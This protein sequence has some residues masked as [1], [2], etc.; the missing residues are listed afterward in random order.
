MELDRLEPRYTVLREIGSGGMGKVFL[1]RDQLLGKELALKVLTSASVTEPGCEDAADEFSLLARIEHPGIARAYDFGY[2]DDVPYFTSEF[3]EGTTLPI[4]ADDRERPDSSTL[5]SNARQLAEALAFLH[6]GGI[7]HLDVKPS[8]VVVTPDDRLVLIDFGL[9]RRSLGTAPTGG[10]APPSA[11]PLRGSLLYMAPEYF[12]GARLGPWTDVYALG[13]TLYQ[14]ATGNLPRRGAASDSSSTE[15]PW[16]PAP[17]PPSHWN[18][19]IPEEFDR[20][21]LKALA[22]DPS[23][24]F[25]SASEFLEALEHVPGASSSVVRGFDGRTTVGRSNELVAIDAYLR[26]VE[27]R[28]GSPG[29][30]MLTG[31]AGMGLSHLLDET[32]IRAQR[33]GLAG[34]VERVEPG[35]VPGPGDLFR[36]LALHLSGEARV[37]W[38]AFVERLRSPRPSSRGPLTQA[39]RR[40]RWRSEIALATASLRGPIVL[41]VDDLERFD[42]VS[43]ILLGDLVR[44]LLERASDRAL[45]ACVGVVI[46]CR[47]RGP[48]ARHIGELS[49]S[50]MASPSGKILALGPL[51]P[52]DCRL[53]ACSMSKESGEHKSGL[54]LFQETGGA[55]GAIVATA[56]ASGADQGEVLEAS[57][58]ERSE[59]LSSPGSP[60]RDLLAILAMIARPLAADALAR[61][62]D[63][64]DAVV[65][66]QLDELQDAGL[67]EEERPGSA[68]AGW[69][70]TSRVRADRA[71]SIRERRAAHRRIAEGLRRDGDARSLLESVRHDEAAGRRSSFVKY[72]LK[73]V[74]YLQDT[75]QNRTAIELLERIRSALPPSQEARRLQVTTTLA[76]LLA[77]VGDFDRGIRLL[78]EQVRETRHIAE[79]ARVKLILRL[80]TLHSRNGDAPL[81]DSLFR[82]GLDAC[83]RGDVKIERVE[84]LGFLS[85]H[86]ALRVFLGDHDEALSL[87]AEGLSIS[88]RCRRTRGLEE[89]VLNVHATRANVLLR[90]FEFEAATSEFRL[91]LQKAETIGSA[92]NQAVILN[93]LGI[94]HS[95]CDEY[96]EAERVFRDAEKTC[97]ELDEGPSLSFIYGNL[98]M[99]H[100]KRGRFADMQEALRKATEVVGVGARDES[101]GNPGRRQ[102]FFF[103]HHSGTARLYQGRFPEAQSHFDEALRLGRSLGDR[104]A[105]AFDEVYHGECLLFGGDYEGAI[106]GLRRLTEEAVPI[107]P[108]RMA[109]ARLALA[110]ALSG[111]DRDAVDLF[112]SSRADDHGAGPR[113]PYVESTND[114]F[115]A[116]A[117]GVAEERGVAREVIG[118]AEEFF[119]ARGLQPG[120]SLAMWLRAEDALATGQP[121][122]ALA[123]AS[124]RPTLGSDLVAV[125]WALLEAR[126]LLEPAER[127]ETSAKRCADRLAEAGAAL[128]SCPLPEWSARLEALRAA[129]PGGGTSRDRIDDARD[130]IASRMP[131]DVRSRYQSSRY[132]A[133]W[134]DVEPIESSERGK[135]SRNEGAGPVSPRAGSE[136]TRTIV[137]PPDERLEMFRGLVA[138]SPAMQQ[139][140]RRLRRIC[141][142]DLPVL[143]RGETGTG[144]ELIAKIIHVEGPRA[145]APLQVI[146]CAAIPEALFESELFGSRRG[147]FTGGDEDRV[148]LLARADGGT[149]LLDEIGKLPLSTQAKLLRVLAEGEA[150]AVGA[151][152]PASVNCRF[153]FTTAED[154]DALVKKGRVRMDFLQRVSV[155]EVVVPPL[156][157][158]REDIPQ[159]AQLFLAD[160]DGAAP[161]VPKGFYEHLAE[162]EWP[163]NARELRNFMLRLR[164]EYSKT[165]PISAAKG[166]AR[167]GDGWAS[168][169]GPAASSFPPELLGAK[170]LEEL[171]QQ[172]DR[173]YILFHLD[174]LEGDTRALSALLGITRKQLYRRLSAAGVQLRARRSER[175]AAEKGQQPR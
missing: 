100:A 42:E 31:A 148:G 24:R 3:V 147:A 159:L 56:G 109:C 107:V 113:I 137:F 1:A 117:L 151:D 173:E 48:F 67:V 57:F 52:V 18:G 140:V 167:P 71:F 138:G 2:V 73:A 49:E 89:I 95:Q 69:K 150:R 129:L 165:V 28:R 46:A 8:N 162:R 161:R 155:L 19:S 131:S 141:A 20:L 39:E 97:L 102:R 118:S 142:S 36:S 119:R 41:A 35:R 22:L 16:R 9:F 30:L 125:L 169:E 53:L 94:V 14:A 83:R 172:L 38:E 152:E 80:A 68:F 88:R 11:V 121:R 171:R 32:K 75:F 55:P 26:G 23:A 15:L 124:S 82:E 127:N 126:C 168:R 63:R 92:V 101:L 79:S 29:V 158:R 59:L 114:L 77:R 132:W 61:F 105:V 34:Y 76:E 143:V 12:Q 84:R 99:L 123:L 163:G 133:L 130:E 6:R 62:V 160:L 10:D 115:W 7:L 27:E 74:A 174:R 104:L 108:R 149:V 103:E 5:L 60:A 136:P 21:L 70:L 128:L 154:I 44:V 146:D 106:R 170:N 164:Y 93:N 72:G 87:C 157:E 139:V 51:D 66:G 13:V 111:R 45:V 78:R 145:D 86:A 40:L 96:Q 64:S 91:S 37:R 43:V 135:G 25:A 175:A 47:Q 112:D 110:F 4:P 17:V 120:L 156:R 58:T 50:L 166:G 65:S 54:Q 85:E 153:L 144:K 134:A 81:A 98:A 90:Q 116:W 33:R 122:A